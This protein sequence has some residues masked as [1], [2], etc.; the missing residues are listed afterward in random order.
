MRKF[1][2]LL[3][4]LTFAL[5]CSQKTVT[6][7]STEKMEED[8]WKPIPLKHWQQTPA[9]NNRIAN[10]QDVIK[11]NAV[12]FIEG[13]SLD[14]KPYK[15]KLPK[16]AYLTDY[17]TKEKSLVVIIQIEELPEKGVVVGYRNIT[18]GNGAGLLNEFEIIN[19]RESEKLSR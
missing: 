7:N 9:I 1:L 3:I 18:G 2:S 10:E 12:Y 4:I 15:I 19:D 13:N 16:L 8:L 5:S 6:Q 11:G 17:E 14:H